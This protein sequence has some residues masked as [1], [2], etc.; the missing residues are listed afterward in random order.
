MD[1]KKLIF[2][3]LG[4][5]F[6]LTSCNDF[7]SLSPD[8]QINEINYYQSENDYETAVVGIYNQLQGLHNVTI[9]YLSELT[10]DNT[11]I[12]WTSPALMKSNVT[13]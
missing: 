8:Y 3:I 11:I 5:L 1:M 2:I 7:L 12:N 9:L 4:V 6:G 10:T 13:K